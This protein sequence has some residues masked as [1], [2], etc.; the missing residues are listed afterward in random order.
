MKAVDFKEAIEWAKRRKVVL[1]EE[2]Y[3]ELRGYARSKSFS[4]A[5]ITALS[6]LLEVMRSLDN[7]TSAGVTFSDWKKEVTESGE[8]ALPDHRLENIFRTNLQNH[9]SRGRCLQQEKVKS[10]RPWFLYDATNDDRTRPAHGAMDGFVASASDKVW[11]VWTPPC[12][13]QCRCKRIALSEEQAVKYRA[14]DD[15]AQ[16]SPEARAERVEALESGPDSGWNYSICESDLGFDDYTTRTL[17]RSP[18]KVAKAHKSAAAFSALEALRKGEPLDL[19]AP[20]NWDLVDPVEFLRGENLATP[21][22]LPYTWATDLGLETLSGDYIKKQSLEQGVDFFALTI[23]NDR[24]NE[25][26]KL[27]TEKRYKLKSQQYTIAGADL[28]SSGNSATFSETTLTGATDVIEGAK[29][30]NIS[31]AMAIVNTPKDAI[32]AA[33][34]S[35]N[36]PELTHLPGAKF[37]VS[38]LGKRKV[39][40]KE[41]ELSVD[42]VEL[43][44][45]DDGSTGVAQLLQS[46]EEYKASK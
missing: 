18:D 3:G 35:S 22:E 1:P 11:A 5:G 24:L 25:L 41:G 13:Y 29:R 26:K 34:V 46:W 45:I 39:I 42:L 32:A 40:T 28:P 37:S 36:R 19:T 15:V 38:S 16:R 8:F 21:S 6:Q 44:L 43:T 4:I 12:G 9:Y 2:Y 10:T 7:A 20:N 23:G 30:A 17:R 33:T 31:G 27:V 14:I